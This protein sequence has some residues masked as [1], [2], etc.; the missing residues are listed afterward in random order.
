[1]LD[2][3][4]TTQSI[5]ESKK[6]NKGQKE[7]ANHNLQNILYMSSHNNK[8]LLDS[9][10]TITRS[11]KVG[12]VHVTQN[13]NQ[14]SV[15]PHNQVQADIIPLNLTMEDDPSALTKTNI[16]SAIRTAVA[17]E[18]KAFKEDHITPIT[19]DMNDIKVEILK[20]KGK[21]L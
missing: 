17:E 21:E 19:K 16:L 5:G 3:C 2:V 9:P 7:I 14:V 13:K 4:K 1:M 15:N 6:S 20:F 8:R 11:S 12:R 18:F 10:E